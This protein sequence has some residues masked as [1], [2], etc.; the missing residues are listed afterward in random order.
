MFKH[1]YDKNLKL[2]T[3]TENSFRIIINCSSQLVVNQGLITDCV[4]HVSIKRNPFFILNLEHHWRVTHMSIIH[5]ETYTTI[6]HSSALSKWR[7]F[8][9]NIL[10]KAIKHDHLS[11]GTPRECNIKSCTINKSILPAPTRVMTVNN[12]PTET[13]VHDKEVAAERLGN[14]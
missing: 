11:I 7:Q 10:L 1:T 6:W 9:G 5:T 12:F 4:K 3:N 2:A 8:S 14:K 13:E